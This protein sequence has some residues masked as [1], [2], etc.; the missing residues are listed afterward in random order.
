M[1]SSMNIRR[2]AVKCLVDEHNTI[3]VTWANHHYLDFVMTWVEHVKSVGVTTY[4]VGA[5]RCMH[6][7]ANTSAGRKRCTAR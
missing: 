6:K 1:L 4:L 3:M 7:L 2:E 5:G